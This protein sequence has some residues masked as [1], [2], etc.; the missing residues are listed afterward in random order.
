MDVKISYLPVIC[1]SIRESVPDQIKVDHEYMIDRLSIWIDREGDSYG[2]VY[3][4]KNRRVGE[5]MLSH[6]RCK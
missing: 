5:M 4:A 3:D 1:I 6:F 2:T